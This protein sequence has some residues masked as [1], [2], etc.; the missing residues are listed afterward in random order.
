M[1]SK[2]VEKWLVYWGLLL[3][4]DFHRWHHS[5]LFSHPLSCAHSIGSGTRGVF[6]SENS[7]QLHRSELHICSSQIVQPET[8]RKPWATREWR[9]KRAGMLNSELLHEKALGH[10]VCACVHV[11]AQSPE[12]LSWF[13]CSS[14]EKCRDEDRRYSCGHS[15][16]E[17]AHR[18][19]LAAS[20]RKLETVAKAEGCQLFK[21]ACG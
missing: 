9:T 20:K 7:Q 14:T 10:Q 13:L 11:F 19:H 8:T 1:F 12:P 18:W 6:S 17:P 5:L 21:W 3:I 4:A 2:G 16:K 15:D